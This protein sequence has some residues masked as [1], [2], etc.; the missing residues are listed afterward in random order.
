MTARSSSPDPCDHSPLPDGLA[1]TVGQLM[2]R[3]AESMRA[4]LG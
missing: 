1:P 3:A 2:D 4:T